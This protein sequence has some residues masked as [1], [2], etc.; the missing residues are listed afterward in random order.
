MFRA[1]SGRQT[2][3][4]L[5]EA[6]SRLTPRQAE[7][8]DLVAS[9]ATNRAIAHHLD[10]SV[11]TIEGYRAA[12]MEKMQAKNVSVLIQQAFRLGRS[13]RKIK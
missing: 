12:I 9:G 13:D 1:A 6:F 7:I 4:A 3:Q 5:T 8:F 2:N 10:V 11:R